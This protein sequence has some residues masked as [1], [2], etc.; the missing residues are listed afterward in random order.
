MRK[1]KKCRGK[2]GSQ[3]I[4]LLVNPD[5]KTEALKGTL[6]ETLKGTLK[7]TAKGTL[8]RTIPT[9]QQTV[10]EP[11]MKL[12]RPQTLP[13]ARLSIVYYFLRKREEEETERER[14]N[15][16]ETKKGRAGGGEGGDCPVS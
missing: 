10:K 11:S 2:E 3:Q 5:L 12:P 4:V 6:E 16:R 1:P 14:E 8:K 13:T 15:E 9:K 7:G